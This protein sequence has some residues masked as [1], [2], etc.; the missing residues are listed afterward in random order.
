MQNCE[1]KVRTE[2]PDAEVCRFEKV[3]VAIANVGKLWSSALIII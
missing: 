1:Q 2:L 3:Y